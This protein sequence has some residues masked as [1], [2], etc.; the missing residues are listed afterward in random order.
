M[1]KKEEVSPSPD[2]SSQEPRFFSKQNLACGGIMALGTIAGGISAHTIFKKTGTYDDDTFDESLTKID[3]GR[4]KT[5]EGMIVGGV[6]SCAVCYF[7]GRFFQKASGTSTESEHGFKTVNPAETL[8]GAAGRYTANYIT[9]KISSLLLRKKE[10]NTQN[11]TK[12]TQKTV[13]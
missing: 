10:D 6:A 8:G 3:T 11:T 13:P 5:F 12:V 4:R 9:D 2:K 7:G 1:Q